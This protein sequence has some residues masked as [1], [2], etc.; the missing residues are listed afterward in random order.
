[1]MISASGYTLVYKFISYNNKSGSS[2]K[3]FRYHIYNYILAILVLLFFKHTI[4]L[5]MEYYL[6]PVWLIFLK[7]NVK[8]VLRSDP[9]ESFGCFNKEDE[10]STSKAFSLLG[11]FGLTHFWPDNESF[12][13]IDLYNYTWLPFNEIMFFILGIIILTFGCKF[14]CRIDIAIIILFFINFGAKIVISIVYNKNKEFYSMF[15]F[16]LFGYGEFMNSFI[17]N[18][19][20][21]LIGMF[22]GLNNYSLEKSSELINKEI[23]TKVNDF[24]FTDSEDNLEKS[25]SKVDN[26]KNKEEKY[27]IKEKDESSINDDLK[28]E[29]SKINNNH[30]EEENELNL[31]IGNILEKFPFLKISNS[32]VNWKK[33]QKNC[34]VFYRILIIIILVLFLILPLIVIIETFKSYYTAMIDLK[35]IYGNKEDIKVEDIKTY[36]KKVGFS[37]YMTGNLNYLLFIDIEIIILLF[38]WIIFILKFNGEQSILSF[39]TSTFWGLFDKCYFSFTIVY[40]LVLL[41]ILHSSENIIPLTVFN[42]ILY[43]LFSSFFIFL[44]TWFLYIYFELP[45]KKLSRFIINISPDYSLYEEEKIIDD[46]EIDETKEKKKIY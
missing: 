13:H 21:F 38:H 40:S 28:N 18:F 15:Y 42:I 30:E 12:K 39:F 31:T 5:L 3:F 25:L 46:E 43:F 35:E 24:V 27:E 44:L 33:R 7:C 14:K 9:T 2:I 22:F 36:Y 37:D 23:Y 32:Y 41:F 19:P 29:E 17:F 16:Y 34:K 10:K 26:N 45:M 20:Y 6:N 11:T 4:N 1:M 8:N